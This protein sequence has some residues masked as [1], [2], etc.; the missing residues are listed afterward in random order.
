MLKIELYRKPQPENHSGPLILTLWRRNDFLCSRLFCFLNPTV[1]AHRVQFFVIASHRPS[2]T[3]F[4]SLH[5]S[6]P[7]KYFPYR[8]Q[9]HPRCA[10]QAPS[11]FR[12]KVPTT[13]QTPTA[14][15]QYDCTSQSCSN[16]N[17]LTRLCT[18]KRKRCLFQ[19]QVCIQGRSWRPWC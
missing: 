11:R 17:S 10:I 8:A 12:C 6:C 2:I 15:L 4:G 16:S 9:L 5:Q 7:V 1:H 14:R 18:R 19:G 13:V 3:P